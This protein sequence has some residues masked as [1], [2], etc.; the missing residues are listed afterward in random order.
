MFTD[1]LYTWGILFILVTTLIAIFKKEKDSSL[2][3]DHVRLNVIQNYSL[4]W[5]IMKLPNIQLL[6]IALLTSRVSTTI[7]YTY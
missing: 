4:L 7:I 3:D 1:I 5:D 6:A 2:E